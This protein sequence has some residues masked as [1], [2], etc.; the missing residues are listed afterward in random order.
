MDLI[1]TYELATT[2]ERLYMAKIFKQMSEALVEPL[3]GLELEYGTITEE[4]QDARFYE[5]VGALSE[6]AELKVKRRR[7]TVC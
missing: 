5:L 3:R 1:H 7:L 2:Q 6:L 4:V